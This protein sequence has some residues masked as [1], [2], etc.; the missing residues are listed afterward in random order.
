MKAAQQLGGAPALARPRVEREA[1][2]D[3]PADRIADPAEGDARVL[4]LA[5]GVEHDVELLRARHRQAAHHHR[6]HRAQREIHRQAL[7][8]LEHAV[9]HDAGVGAAQRRVVLEREA[10]ARGTGAGSRDGSGRGAIQGSPGL[11]RE[12]ERAQA[13]LEVVQAIDAPVPLAAVEEHAAEVVAELLAQRGCPRRGPR[14]RGGE[15]R[16][17][18]LARERLEAAAVAAPERRARPARPASANAPPAIAGSERARRQLDALRCRRRRVRRERE[19]VAGRDVRRVAPREVG[20]PLALGRRRVGRRPDQ[21]RLERDVVA[22]QQ[23][24]Q[25]LAASWL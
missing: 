11:P 6:Q 16:D 14:A 17:A 8:K 4:G 21:V 18:R 2:L 10:L 13:A 23:R 1:A 25:H 19:P 20:E 3:R 24:G 12:P 22:G 5:L 7:R 15:V 9:H